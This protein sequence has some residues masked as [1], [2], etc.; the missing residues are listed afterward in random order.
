MPSAMPRSMPLPAAAS[1]AVIARYAHAAGTSR[2][3]TSR[4]T[5]SN[6]TIVA[7]C[8]T[9][10]VAV[11]P[12]VAST[13]ASTG[14][15][16]PENTPIWSSV[17]RQ[18]DSTP[19]KSRRSTAAQPSAAAMSIQSLASPPAAAEKPR[20]AEA[21]ST[22][23]ATRNS[24]PSAVRIALW[25]SEV[26][27]SSTRETESDSVSAFS[28]DTPSRYCRALFGIAS[29]RL[30]PPTDCTCSSLTAA[31]ANGRNSRS[32]RMAFSASLHLLIPP[33]P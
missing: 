10:A 6:T 23:T 15:S 28:G 19:V 11:L 27:F 18:S 25:L 2:A 30:L 16:V 31:C 29:V 1:T 26:M 22:I 7:A 5:R 8:K 14:W 33:T 3:F 24:P 12:P 20:A 17:S 9:V 4:I 13:V 21:S 32:T